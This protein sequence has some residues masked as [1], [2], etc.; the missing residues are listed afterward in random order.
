LKNAGESLDSIVLEMAVARYFAGP[1]PRRRAADYL[2]LR[3]L[4]S[5]A[6]VPV[7]A[8][9]PLDRLPARLPVSDHPLEAHGSA[10]ALVDT[11]GAGSPFTLKVWLRGESGARWS[12][13]AVR[14]SGDGRERGRTAAA[15]RNSPNSYLSVELGPG[16]DRVLLV[17]T[18]LPLGLVDADR[19]TRN[20][21]AFQLIID[22]E[23]LGPR[24]QGRPAEPRRSPVQP[25]VTAPA[26]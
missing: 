6:A 5:N 25:A 14:L 12:L 9:V 26:W 23:G 4:A 24:K 7:P 8:A 3:A 21:R 1:E 2:A 13:T 19:D 18:H 17:V 22:A 16:I 10:Y 15:A 20:P 11:S